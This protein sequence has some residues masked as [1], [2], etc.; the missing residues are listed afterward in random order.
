MERNRT[1]TSTISKSRRGGSTTTT[2]TAGPA[3]KSTPISTD[4]AVHTASCSIGGG[5][6]SHV[7]LFVGNLD[8][9]VT[10]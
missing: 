10:E 9:R 8:T 2:T 5:G 1:V 3:S 7:R 6:G 4:R